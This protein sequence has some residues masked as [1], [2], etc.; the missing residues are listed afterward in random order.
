MQPLRE[1][2]ITQRKSIS[3]NI[4]FVNVKLIFA[5]ITTQIEVMIESGKVISSAEQI[6]CGQLVLQSPFHA[7]DPPDIRQSKFLEKLAS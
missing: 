1:G 2:I 3:R 4:S 6:S 7:L 5:Q